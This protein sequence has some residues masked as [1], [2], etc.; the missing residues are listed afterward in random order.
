MYSED[1]DDI[2]DALVEQKSELRFE[3]HVPNTQYELP[4]DKKSLSI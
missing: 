3:N 4:L 1:L 2:K